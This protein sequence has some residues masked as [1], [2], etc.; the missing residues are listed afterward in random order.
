MEEQEILYLTEYKNFIDSYKRGEVSGEEVGEVIIKMAQHY[1]RYNM[2]M[3]AK[4]R[5]VHVRAAEFESK[6]DENGKTISSTKAKVLL[7]ATDEYY[8]YSIARAHLMNIEQ[9]INALKSLQKGVL[10]E[11]QHQN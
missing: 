5:R 11:Y 9:F 7:E 1:S 2:E 3:V 10:N 6:T 4:D 8:D